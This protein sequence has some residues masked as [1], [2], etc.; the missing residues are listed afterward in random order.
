MRN[1][2]GQV[3][4]VSP[5]VSSSNFGNPI[6]QLPPNAIITEGM[7]KKFK[8]WLWLI[9]ILVLLGVGI[10]LFFLLTGGSDGGSLLSGGGSSIPR[11][12]ALPSG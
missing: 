1:K 4:P 8:W 9:M 11:P 2:R 6:R 12:P 5:G 7:P 3:Q 10:G